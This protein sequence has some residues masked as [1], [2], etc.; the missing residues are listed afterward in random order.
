MG[1]NTWYQFRTAISED[2]ILEQA[3][4]LVSSGLAAAGYTC[5]NLDDGWMAPARA[6]DG[7]MVPDPAKFPSGIKALADQLHALGLRSGLYTA[8]GTRTC[9]NLPGSWGHY[10]Q[11]AQTYADWG[12]DFVKVDMCGGVPAGITQAAITSSFEQ[13]GTALR[14]AN[15]SVAYSQELPIF[16]MGTP[17]FVQSVRDSA[18]FSN[19]WRVV[20]DEYPLTHANAYPTVLAHLAQ[21]WHLHSFGGWGHW[22]DLDMVAPGYPAVSGWTPQDL[23]NQLAV[24][25]ME[26]SPLLIS[27]DIGTLPADALASLANPMLITIDQSGNQCASSVT[28]GSVQALTKPY[29]GGGI[30]ACFLNMGTGATSAAFT[31]AQL[32]ITSARASGTD[33]WSGSSTQ[34]TGVS[35]GLSAGQVRLLRIMPLLQHLRRE[36][37]GLYGNDGTRDRYPD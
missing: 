27:A 9:Q 17:G 24:W 15:P 3:N 21:D 7:S 34:F 22:N 33:V 25:A 26:A 13:F 12:I 35:I 14:A 4:L 20:P 23:K 30:A 36:S 37:K 2:L 16:A 10:A 8:I 11:D 31:L 32:G 19:M 18:T 5:V 6:A 29:P 1:F 28:V